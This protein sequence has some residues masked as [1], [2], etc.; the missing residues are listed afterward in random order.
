MTYARE[1]ISKLLLE[2]VND[3]WRWPLWWYTLGF[4]MVLDWAAQSIKDTWERLAIGLFFKY[5]FKPMYS[6]YTWSGRAIS[7]VMRFI[8][9]IYKLIRLVLWS[10]WYL[11]LVLF[12]LTVLPVAIFFIFF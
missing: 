2:T 3:L 4:K 12:W 11:L 1:E 10:G 7:L 5:F 8:L 6:D 9:I